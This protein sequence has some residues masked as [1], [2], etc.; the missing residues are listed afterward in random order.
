MIHWD[1]FQSLRVKRAGINEPE[2]TIL[3]AFYFCRKQEH[4]RYF[5]DIK[6]EV[7]VA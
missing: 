1:R 3:L 5:R 2:M 4:P 7:S 6:A